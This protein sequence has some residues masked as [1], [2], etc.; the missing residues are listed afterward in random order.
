MPPPLQ[1]CFSFN[2]TGKK[3]AYISNSTHVLASKCFKFISRP[4]DNTGY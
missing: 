3:E 2:F 1:R 4:N